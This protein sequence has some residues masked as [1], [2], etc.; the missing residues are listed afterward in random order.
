MKQLLLNPWVWTKI[1][2]NKYS[3][4][5]AGESVPIIYQTEGHRE[6]IPYQRWISNGYVERQ[7]MKFYSSELI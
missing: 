1:A 4:R 6:Y 3:N 7:E 2:E 5:R